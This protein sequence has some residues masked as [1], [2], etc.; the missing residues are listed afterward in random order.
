VAPRA[1][2]ATNAANATVPRLKGFVIN[3][4]RRT[5]RR[6]AAQAELNNSWPTLDYEFFEAIA[7]MSDHKMGCRWS[8]FRALQSYLEHDSSKYDAVVIMEDDLRITKPIEKELTLIPSQWDMMF[9]SYRPLHVKRVN[10]EP[11][12]YRAVHGWSM[13]SYIVSNKFLPYYI[14]KVKQALE[15]PVPGNVRDHL[16]GFEHISMLGER[17][18]SQFMADNLIM[19]PE[20]LWARPSLAFH[21]DLDSHPPTAAKLQDYVKR[22]HWTT[23]LTDSRLTIDR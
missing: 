2:V 6:A 5:D 13:M 16:H 3:L 14:G 4:A 11:H 20:V 21:S 9:V 23:E 19:V 17:E 15:H 22:V 12:W 1:H 10:S 7:N 18:A 8:H